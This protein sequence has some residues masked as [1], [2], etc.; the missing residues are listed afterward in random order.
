[1]E[2]KGGIADRIGSLTY[3]RIREVRLK[4]VKIST[5]TQKAGRGLALKGEASEKSIR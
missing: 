1:M 4:V 2:G 5:V 3:D